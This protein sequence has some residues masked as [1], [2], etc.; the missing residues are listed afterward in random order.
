[1]EKP[2]TDIYRGWSISVEAGHQLCAKFSFTVTSPS[3]YSQHVAI[4]GENRERAVERARE[5][6][7][8]EI[9]LTEEE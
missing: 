4:G 2:L 5:L 6:I 1:M 9:A 8:M 7:D 3:G